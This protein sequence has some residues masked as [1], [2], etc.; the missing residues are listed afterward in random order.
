MKNLLLLLSAFFALNLNAS[1]AQAPK[2]EEKSDPDAKKILDKLRDKYKALGSIAAEFSLVIEMGKTK[3]EQSGKMAQNGSKYRVSVGNNEIIS[4]GAS[5][6]LYNKQQNEVQ[7]NEYTPDNNDMLSPD[8]LLKIYES[9]KEFIYVIT[10]D[11]SAQTSIE[12]KPLD[13]DAEF[14]KI[15][16]VYDKAK[17]EATSIKVFGKDGSRYTLNI[18]KI[19][20]QTYSDSHF[21]FDKSKYP[22]VVVTDLR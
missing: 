15:R 2:F 9:D 13:K 6:W 22:G 5:T 16:M 20:S 18:K 11:N 3:E 10:E 12:F 14:F 7:I 21:A 4:D 19:A 17:N 8:K 1:F